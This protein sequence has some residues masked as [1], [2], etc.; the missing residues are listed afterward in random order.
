MQRQETSI[1]QWPV[2]DLTT[3]TCKGGLTILTDQAKAV[4][5][6]PSQQ[7]LT[8]SNGKGD[9]IKLKW[10]ILTVLRLWS[11]MEQEYDVTAQW[12]CYGDCFQAMLQGQ[13]AN[14]NMARPQILPPKLPMCLPKAWHVLQVLIKDHFHPGYRHAGVGHRWKHRGLAGAAPPGGQEQSTFH[15]LITSN[16]IA[17]LKF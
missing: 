3:H 15:K 7:P 14:G 5:Q 16:N 6:T 4:H 17:Q 8:L 2:G 10:Y 1:L 9:H 12:C 13:C 11:D